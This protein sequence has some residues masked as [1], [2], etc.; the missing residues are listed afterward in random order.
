MRPS[1]D[2]TPDQELVRESPTYLLTT[3]N[4]YHREEILFLVDDGAGARR[5]GMDRLG[6]L[7]G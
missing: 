1:F 3:T 6:R 5:T 4:S 2:S 7:G